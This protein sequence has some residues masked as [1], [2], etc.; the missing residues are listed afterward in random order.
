MPATSDI[1][2]EALVAVTGIFPDRPVTYGDTYAA[3]LLPGEWR[4]SVKEFFDRDKALK[5]K[6]TKLPMSYEK[7]GKLLVN[8]DDDPNWLTSN[9]SDPDVANSYLLVISNAR[10]YLR[11]KWPKLIIQ[12]Y[13]LP[14]PVDP[15]RTF[16]E[17]MSM[18]YCTVNEPS[19]ILREMISRS[20]Q[21]A[22]VD[23]FK[24]VF[25][26]LYNLLL[27]TIDERKQLEL[28]RSMSWTVPWSKE[29][30]LRNLY[31]LPIE[32]S[33]QEAPR[34]EA[35]MGNVSQ[36]KMKNS[37]ETTKSQSLETKEIR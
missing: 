24:T 18:L 31:Q 1:S 3:T 32:S 16:I 4:S 2:T 22:Q 10:E 13:P 37:S 8:P 25:P 11:S 35:K 34:S 26:A 28:S 20:L 21:P 9:F 30:I 36:I 5:F 19:I 12:A 7:T 27:D 23:A 14:R 29:R 15:G 33:I 17:E 6:R